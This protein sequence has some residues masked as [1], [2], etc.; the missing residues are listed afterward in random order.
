LTILLG[1]LRRQLNRRVPLPARAVA[2]VG[3]GP[4]QRGEPVLPLRSQ[5]KLI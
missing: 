4:L 5:L 1:R 2:P 3:L